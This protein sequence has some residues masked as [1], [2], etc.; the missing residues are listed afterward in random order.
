[1]H[2]LYIPKDAGEQSKIFEVIQNVLASDQDVT[3]I[4]MSPGYLGKTDKTIR[5][6][7]S[8]FSK[9]ASSRKI[10]V[11]ITYGM[12]GMNAMGTGTILD[13][14]SNLLGTSDAPNLIYNPTHRMLPHKKNHRKVM[15]FADMDGG[16]LSVHAALVGSSNQCYETYIKKSA[17][18]EAD[19]LLIRDDRTDI[20]NTLEN[21]PWEKSDLI[22]FKSICGPAKSDAE[23]LKEI[24]E[25]VLAGD[26]IS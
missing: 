4:I 3:R 10:K 24:A 13:A 20:I 14:H 11:T 25:N 8:S 23:Y 1:M 6:F 7:L 17:K 5:E 21:L 15:I 26:T 19:V 22:L 2:S 12:N 18:G 16:A 9:C